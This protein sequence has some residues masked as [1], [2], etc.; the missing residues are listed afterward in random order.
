ML[1]I[2]SR[3]IIL[4]HPL[5]EGNNI[6]QFSLSFLLYLGRKDEANTIKLWVKRKEKGHI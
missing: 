2:H 6:I 3:S 5:R 4:D 1:Q